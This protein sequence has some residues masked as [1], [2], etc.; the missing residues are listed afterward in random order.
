MEETQ[1][2]ESMTPEW[3]LD[4]AHQWT[5]GGD[6]VLILKFVGKD[7]SSYG[8]YI[9]PLTVGTRIEAPDWGTKPDNE[10]GGGFHGWPWGIGIGEGKNPDWNATWLVFGETPDNVLSLGLK[11]K[12]KSAT[13]RFIGSWDQAANFVLRGQMSLIAAC[14]SGAASATGT[15]GAA[16]ATGTSGAASA[17]GESGAASATGTRGAASATGWSGAASATG[18]SGAA[19][20]T[21]TRGAASATGT[22]GAASATGESGAAS[23][24]GTS[25]KARAGKY[26]CIALAW[27]NQTA[28]RTEMQCR[29]I[30]CGD[31]SDGKLKAD[32][33]FY[34]TK[35]GEFREC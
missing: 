3:S 4:R 1:N 34:L 33:W 30:G 29:Q 27:W 15:R 31:G 21:G 18:T 19:S 14:T 24:T 13:I 17:T 7:G 32:T 11:V 5:N 26:G 25:S 28:S 23:A 10:C 16:S 20:A 35:E 2:K 9:W 8:G 12:T 22:S 6:E